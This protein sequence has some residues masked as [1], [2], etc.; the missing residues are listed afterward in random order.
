VE[1]DQN[2]SPRATFDGTDM[3]NWPHSSL[4]TC[5]TPGPFLWAPSRSNPIVGKTTEPSSFR[6]CDAAHRSALGSWNRNGGSLVTPKCL[7]SPG[8][9]V[10]TRGRHLGDHLMLFRWSVP[11][12]SLP[13]CD[14][15]AR[16]TRSQSSRENVK[17]QRA[18][19]FLKNLKTRFLNVCGPPVRPARASMAEQRPEGEF[20]P[21]LVGDYRQQEISAGF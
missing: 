15:N 13:I 12:E 7:G 10:R 9:A 19:S 14:V 18:R 21:F 3:T 2:G 1:Q 5:P 6:S 20:G 4:P 17:S 16:V 11:V 8:P